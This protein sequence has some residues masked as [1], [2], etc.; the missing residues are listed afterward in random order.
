M[1]IFI[2]YRHEDTEW[3]T[4]TLFNELKQQMP[5]EEIFKDFNTIK[6]G[7]DFT[8]AIERNLQ[9]C[10]VLL[11]IIGQRWLTC[12]DENGNQRLFSQDDY[13]CMEIASALSSNKKV[14]P[15]LVDNA[16]MP[17][18][19]ELPEKIKDLFK[20]QA[21]KIN[22]SNFEMDVF[23]LA[24]SIREASGQQNKYADLVKDIVTGKVNKKDL[25]KPE[26]HSAY[27]L[28]CIGLGVLILLLNT[29]S[30]PVIVICIAMI[31]AGAYA[32]YLSRNI[33]AL[34]LN[35]KFEEARQHSKNIKLIS[36][37]APVAGLVLI[38]VVIILQSFQTLS[39]PAGNAMLNKIM[40]V[41]AKDSLSNVKQ[42][43]ASAENKSNTSASTAEPIS[44]IVTNV[45][46]QQGEKL[47]TLLQNTSIFN[48][49]D[50]N[51]LSAFY[52][53]EGTVVRLVSV[54]DPFAEVEFADSDGK[55][56]KG[57]I[58][59]VDLEELP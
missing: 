56:Y 4:L 58:A 55:L 53:Y 35:K 38:F 26:V 36:I 34:W 20:R 15:V 13:V 31:L 9:A 22:S 19:S 37:I 10:S 21:I 57:W 29:D 45:V 7:E 28:F 32:F 42:E 40:E 49:P 14:I 48:S 17:N 6:A 33:E 8:K 12:K 54:Q 27:P 46:A 50:I 25:V 16:S 30:T 44:N 18:E 52:L 39:T 59:F 43:P 23:N 11:V 47:Y 24:Q 3:V 41:Q 2:S 51:D 1:K 5:E